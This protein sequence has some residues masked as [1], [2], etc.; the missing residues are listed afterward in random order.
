MTTKATEAEVA[1]SV[2]E[3]VEQDCG[4][5]EGGEWFSENN[6]RVRSFEECGVMTSNAG[7]VVRVGDREFQVTV[8]RSR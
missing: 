5:R 1:R 2:Q 6:V 7:F 4:G 8:V 3:A